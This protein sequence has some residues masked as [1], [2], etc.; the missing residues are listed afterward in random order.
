MS[1]SRLAVPVLLLLAACTDDV[2]RTGAPSQLATAGVPSSNE[3]ATNGASSAAGFPVVTVSPTASA[4]SR[5]PRTSSIAE[6]VRMVAPGGKI[7]VESGTYQAQDVEINKPLSMEGR[8]S[9]KPVIEGGTAF[10]NLQIRGVTDGAVTIRGLTFRKSTFANIYVTNQNT[11]L[12]IENSDFFPGSQGAA[13]PPIGTYTGILAQ[14]ASGLIL[15]QGNTFTGGDVGVGVTQGSTG[16]TVDANSFI[17]Q[18]NAAVHFGD[19]GSEATVSRNT[20]S[21]CGPNWCIGGFGG[22]KLWVD[23]NTIRVDYARPVINAL[24]LMGGTYYVTGNVITGT[25]GTRD[26]N[27]RMT[28]P[29]NSNAIAV[30]GTATI[31]GNRISGAS[32]GLGLGW[33]T[34]TGTDNVISDV[35]SPFNIHEATVNLHRNDFTGYTNPVQFINAPGA[36]SVACNWWGS[37]SGPQN[38]PSW[39]DAAIYT[40]W[41]TQPIANTSVAC[42]R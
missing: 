17:R 6:A 11:K 18:D 2:T 42:N 23:Y 12:V 41:A 30:Q 38:R 31:V 5:G 24:Q 33:V 10:A 25:G 39:L 9:P 13:G 22:S 16:V 15:I 7:I 20:I 34:A 35:G 26:P 4:T 27:D 19:D 21:G 29:M 1:Y 32:N 36:S 40:P 3:S 14:R 37:A 8:N 28:W